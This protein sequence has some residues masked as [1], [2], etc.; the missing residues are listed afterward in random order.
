MKYRPTRAYLA[1]VLFVFAIIFIID[2]LYSI[3]QR[4]VAPGISPETYWKHLSQQL[5][6]APDTQGQWLTL[7]DLAWPQEHIDQLKQQQYLILYDEQQKAV[8]HGYHAETNRVYVIPISLQ[9]QVGAHRLWALLFYL[10]IALALYLWFRPMLKDVYRLKQQALEFAHHKRVINNT[11]SKTSA[12]KPV[13]S[14][15]NQ[16]SL[17]IQQL[18]NLQKD[19]STYV[20]H[21]IRTP[22]ARIKFAIESIDDNDTRDSI[23]EEIHEIENL[24][25]ELL[26]YSQFEHERPKLKLAH[27]NLYHMIQPLTEKYSHMSGLNITSDVLPD[28]NVKIDPTLFK[29]ILDNLLNNS[30]RFANDRINIRYKRGKEQHCLIVE[31]DGP[32]FVLEQLNNLSKPFVR[33]ESTSSGENYGLG[34][35]IVE[36]ICHWHHGQLDLTNSPQL[37]GAQFI[38]RWS[39]NED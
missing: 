19:I 3:L 5:E 9:P 31:D 34:L 29:R 39:I 10:A 27:V 36:T 7:N 22:L 21:D 16:M 18:M 38:V 33:H 25:S 1:L 13:A 28:V 35:A 30:L 26:N 15:L 4:P 20:S 11:L 17:K 14:A 24:I 32:G 2:L 37:N 12:L 23:K 6:K 8:F